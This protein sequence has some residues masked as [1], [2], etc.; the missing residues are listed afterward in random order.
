MLNQ[1]QKNAVEFSEGKCCILACAGSGK[2]A[3]L[4]NRAKNLITQYHI[5]P[6]K[7]MMISFNRSSAQSLKAR[8]EQEIGSVAA[9]QIQT[10]TFH[11]LG[12]KIILEFSRLQSLSLINEKRMRRI[13]SDI[14]VGHR[15]YASYKDIDYISIISYISAQKSRLIE[16][17][18]EKVDNAELLA[19][20]QEYVKNIL[21]GK[22]FLNID[23][24][25]Q[26]NREKWN[27]I[28]GEYEKF[29]KENNLLDF[30]DLVYQAV[31]IL[32][33]NQDF[34]EKISARCQ[35]IMID[36]A[37]DMNE[38]QWTFTELIGQKYGNIFVVGDPCQNIYTWRGASNNRMIDFLHSDDVKVIHL[39]RNYRSTNQIIE[40]ANRV[41]MSNQSSDKEIYTPMISMVGDG[42]TPILQSYQTIN[43]EADDII[44]FIQMR[45]KSEGDLQYDDIA[46]IARTNAQLMAFES[47]MYRLGIPYHC[48][49]SNSLFEL[50]EIKVLLAYLA[51]AIN[52]DDN[53]AFCEVYNKPQ[54]NLGA[55]F[56]SKVKDSAEIMHC[57]YIKSMQSIRLN[58]LHQSGVKELL[59]ILDDIQKFIESKTGPGMVIEFIRKR[60]HYDAYLTK[61]YT[62][63]EI[64]LEDAISVI[65]ALS[66]L[67]LNYE[68]ITVFLSEIKILQHDSSQSTKKGVR[69]MTIHQS[70]GLEFPVVFIIGV[71][72]GILPHKLGDVTEERRLFYVAITRAKN[73]LYLSS[74]RQGANGASLGYS[75]FLLDVNI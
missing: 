52:P 18:K 61:Q 51:L 55:S 33:S 42:M 60:I 58:K 57:S 7:I 73:E 45:V 14:C 9:A 67:A 48:G 30:D 28:Y 71:S 70:K 36:E 16:P 3:V 17:Q 44:N 47:K 59:E 20:S 56:L 31:L 15:L 29:K 4:V 32:Q 64:M 74:I 63:N 65:N 19:R 37:Q 54:R 50:K 13:I 12:Y 43:H 6:K 53:Q 38:A 8:L 34:C 46:I 27:F 5:K 23:N 1:E 21:A 72:D 2:T 69:L 49:Q 24:I 40:M 39:F 75:R 68:S 66:V 35:Y 10:N 62:N 11:S 26:S 41:M 25:T 22:Q